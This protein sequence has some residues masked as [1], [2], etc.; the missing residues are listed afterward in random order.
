VKDHGNGAVRSH[1]VG[2]QAIVAREATLDQQIA[3]KNRLLGVEGGP[4][5]TAHG[6]HQ[7]AHRKTIRWQVSFQLGLIDGHMV[8]RGER[9]RAWLRE[10]AESA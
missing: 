6:V 5:A 10:Q 8:L 1:S 4:E 3:S 9:R 7:V 2:A